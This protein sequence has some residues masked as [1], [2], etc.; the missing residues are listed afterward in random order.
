MI[1]PDMHGG[2]V[3]DHLK[4]INPNVKVLIATGYSISGQ[5]EEV[6]ARGCAGL[7]QKPYNIKTL[8][9]AI[10]DILNT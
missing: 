1:M 9:K 2:V 7:I 6:V 8:S 4:A 10:R 3:F 5:T